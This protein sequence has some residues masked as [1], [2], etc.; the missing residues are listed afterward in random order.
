[1]GEPAYA[2]PKA[3]EQELTS[4]MQIFSDAERME[5]DASILQASEHSSPAPEICAE[6]KQ[7]LRK[8]YK[9]YRRKSFVPQMDAFDDLDHLNDA[10]E[11]E[12]EEEGKEEGRLMVCEMHR[13]KAKGVA[14]FEY[15]CV[16]C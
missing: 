9:R 10:E 5:K 12:E 8:N 1:M 3:P 11:E 7:T 14:S 13:N 2:A 6:K 4:A 16:K 15:E